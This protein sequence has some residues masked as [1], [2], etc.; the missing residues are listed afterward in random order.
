MVGRIEHNRSFARER[1]AATCVWLYRW[2]DNEDE[3][4]VSPP[5]EL[6]AHERA[7]FLF[8]RNESPFQRCYH[9]AEENCRV[10]LQLPA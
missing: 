7:S 5:Q 2:N 3:D 1:I 6:L 4:E 10:L 9:V 8:W